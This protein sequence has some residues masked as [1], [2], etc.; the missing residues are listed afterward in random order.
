MAD[1]YQITKYIGLIILYNKNPSPINKIGRNYLIG[2]NIL[3]DKNSEILNIPIENKTSKPIKYKFIIR[4]FC[5]AQL[6]MKLK[7]IIRIKHLNN[8]DNY[9]NYLVIIKPNKYL[10]SITNI[11]TSVR[12]KEMYWRAFYDIYSHKQNPFNLNEAYK[13]FTEA[14]TKLKINTSSSIKIENIYPLLAEYY[15]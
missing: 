5:K 7:N 8:I 6:K 2:T 9:H 13:T 4:K 11:I 14:P 1:T 12:D 3:V 10:S 15:V